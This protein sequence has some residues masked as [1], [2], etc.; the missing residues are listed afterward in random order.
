MITPSNILRHELIGLKA[1]VIDSKNLSQKG[2]K[3]EVIDETMNTLSI[4]TANGT[5]IIQKEGCVIRF[6]L[7][8]QSVEIDGGELCSRPEDRIKTRI[9]RW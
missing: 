3:G 1:E 4:E 6:F 7:G 5:K 9:R 8:R 2:L